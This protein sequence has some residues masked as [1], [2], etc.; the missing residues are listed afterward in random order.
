MYVCNYCKRVLKES[1]EKCPGCG[2]SSF[3]TKADLGEVIIKNPPKDGYK[4]NIK[5]YK[6]KLR[7]LNIAILVTIFATI[8]LMIVFF[9]MIIMPLI[10]GFIVMCTCINLKIQTKKNIKR[11]EKLCKTGTLVKGLK[12]KLVNTGTMVAGHY[13]K[14]I[15]VKYKNANGVEIPIY[16]ETKYDADKSKDETVDLLIDPDDYSNY[17]IDYEIY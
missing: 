12:Y 17:F 16:S 15:E 6:R 13:Y 4:I 9:P 8:G 2:S 1:Y 14:C 5:N 11:V 10:M 7:D 3:T